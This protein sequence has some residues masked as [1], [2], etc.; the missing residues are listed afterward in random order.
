MNS[1]FWKKFAT[2][3]W[4]K[5]A[6][7]EKNFKSPLSE[8]KEDQIFDMLVEY[9]DYCRKVKKAEGFKLYVEGQLQHEEEILQILPVKNDLSF[10]DYNKRLES[11]FLDYCLVCDELLLVSQKN[12]T[13]LSD[14]TENLFS[15][16]GFPNRFAEMGLYLG[17]YRKTPFGVHADGCGVFSFPVVGRKKFRLWKPE[18]AKKNP[19]L[20]RAHRYSKFN[21]DSITLEAVPGDMTY[22]PSSAW[23]IAESD[24]SFSATWSLGVWV[25]KS[26]QQ[27][28]QDALKPL[29]KSKLSKWGQTYSVNRPSQQKCDEGVLLPENFLHSISILRKISEN[30]LHDALLKSWMK[31]SSKKGFKNSPRVKTYRKLSLRSQISATQSNSIFWSKLKSE[32]KTLYAFQGILLECTPSAQLLKLIK[33]LNRGHLCKISDFLKGPHKINDLKSLNILSKAG[34]FK[35]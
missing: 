12:L 34:A 10:L 9:S 6:V 7:L 17:N 19:K 31:L 21:K 16:V 5:K 33:L 22:W 32:A 28:L 8:I 23:H 27:N 20:D 4:E 26:H 2:S 30:E 25:D 18:F 13:K 1:S 35:L 14:F 24:G 29:I 3:T 15:Y 11:I